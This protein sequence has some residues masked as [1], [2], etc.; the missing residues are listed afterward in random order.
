MLRVTALGFIADPK[1]IFKKFVITARKNVKYATL[2]NASTLPKYCFVEFI[3]DCEKA[4][5]GEK[6]IINNAESSKT[7]KTISDKKINKIYRKR[8]D[9]KDMKFDN[10]KISLECL[11]NEGRAIAY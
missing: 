7:K 11:Y 4:I 10:Q 8:Q 2:I 6:I 5:I 1:N 9:T 3:Y